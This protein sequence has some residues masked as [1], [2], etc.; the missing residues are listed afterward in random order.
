MR[1]M[2]QSI[3]GIASPLGVRFGGI[4]RSFV[5]CGDDNRV[6][7]DV[8]HKHILSAA[9]AALV[10]SPAFAQNAGLTANYGEITLHTGFTPDPYEIQVTAGG[11]INGAN[12]PGSCTGMISD[13]PDFKVNYTAGSLPLTIRTISQTDT[14][15]IIN[16]PS[17]NWAC[18][19]DSYGDG[20]AK[21]V[22]SRPASGR[23]DIWVGTFSGGN[24]RT[25]LQ[26]TELP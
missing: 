21:V 6:E 2:A 17:G 18:D 12:L 3:L 20:D 5:E 13:A 15:L 8:M 9:L 1:M 23:Y 14:T 4:G 19:D 10:I 26:L 22:F 25:R 24:A 16:D 11:N 7:N